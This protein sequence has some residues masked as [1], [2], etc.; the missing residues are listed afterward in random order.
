MG[1]LEI[2]IFLTENKFI[3]K[4]NVLIIGASSGIGFELASQLAGK[5]NVYA[6][7]RNKG[8]LEELDNVQWSS[9]DV[10]E[11]TYDFSHLPEAVD[12]LVFCP[13]SIILKPLRGLKTEEVLHDF[14]LNALGGM[15]VV[16]QLLNK[17]KKSSGASIVFFSTVAVRQGMPFHA[18]VAMAKGAIEGLTR[19]LAAELAPGIRVNA[20]APSLTDTPL[21]SRLLSSDERKEASAQ[22]HPLKRLGTP[23]DMASMAGFLISDEA[24]WITGQII[25]VDGGMGALKV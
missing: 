21:A 22:R 4:K 8:A 19:S 25:G 17:L 10:L 9:I 5:H 3:M 16:Q 24:S 12:A 6:M 23:A 2:T 1:Y 13:G 18:S 20:I 15:R 11:E 7:S 14:K